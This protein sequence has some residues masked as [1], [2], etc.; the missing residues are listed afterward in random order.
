MSKPHMV[1]EIN[2]PRGTRRALLIRPIG[3]TDGTHDWSHISRILRWD[4][5]TQTTYTPTEFPAYSV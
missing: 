3:L 2:H 1:F 5:R 4:L